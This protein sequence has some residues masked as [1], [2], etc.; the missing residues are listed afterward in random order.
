MRYGIDSNCDKARSWGS[1]LLRRG[2]TMIAMLIVIAIIAIL[3][4]VF[5]KGGG[6]LNQ[7]KDKIG[8]T[9]VGQ[10]KADAKDDVCRSNLQQVRAS[11]QINTDPVENTF[12]ARLEDT[13]LGNDFYSCPLGH[14]PYVY[15]PKTGQ[16]HCVHPG[17]EKY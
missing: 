2:Q 8:N 12:P 14:E 16:V 10:M 15:D 3:A 7:R 4:V 13:K 1:A 9:I 11:I 5:L 6:G 17:H